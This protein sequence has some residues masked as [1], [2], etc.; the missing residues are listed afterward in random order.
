MAS[1]AVPVPGRNCGT[2]TMCCKLL[3]VPPLEKPRGK[4]CEH[5]VQGTGCGIYETRPEECRAYYCAWITSPEMGPE[6]KPELSH[7]IVEPQPEQNRIFINVD[8]GRPDAWLKE[9]FIGMFRRWAKEMV[10][11]HRQV[12]VRNRFRT[13]ALLPDG[14]TDLG[15]VTDDDVI[16]METR[17]S[18][19]QAQFR[20]FKLA[21]DDP[22]LAEIR[23]RQ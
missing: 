16:V 3:A 5:C 2:C 17:G 11:T 20:F 15:I 1:G 23:K 12:L 14:Q 4:W 7:F 8:P 13:I 19:P 6:W 21:K 18:G 9:P 22:A 10:Q